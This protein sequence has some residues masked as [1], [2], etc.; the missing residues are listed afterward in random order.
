MDSLVKTL[1]KANLAYHNGQPIM[2][3]DEYDL[4][5]EKLRKLSPNH[6]F[7][8]VIGAPVSKGVLLPYT[9]ASQNKIRANSG[10]LEKWLLRTKNSYIVSDKLD[11]L[12]ALYVN[13]KSL[14]LRGDGVKGVNVSHMIPIIQGL[15]STPCIVRGELVLRK[16]DTVGIGRSI[17]NGWMHRHDDIPKEASK[18]RFVAYQ[19]I[20]PAGM[21]R[22]AQM[23]WLSENGFEIPWWTSISRQCKEAELMKLLLERKSGE[24]PIDGLVVAV[25]SVPLGLSVG[26]VKNPL[27]S[28]A[29]KASLD[30]QKAETTI[31]G[32]VWTTS[33]QNALIPRIQIEP[34]EIGGARIEWLSGHN[35]SYISENRLGTGARIIVRRSGD[36]I[37]CLDSVLEPSLVEFEIPGHDW[38]WDASRVHA[39]VS[40]ASPS[41][42]LL[43]ALQT[44]GVEG[45]GP[46]LVDS[47]VEGGIT[48]M[49]AL[50]KSKAEDLA[51]HI[52]SGRAPVLV[53]SLKKARASASYSTLLVASNRLPRGVG[54]RKMRVLF[55]REPNPRKWTN[56]SAVGWSTESL[57][58]LLKALPFALAW[59]EGSF[60][61]FTAAAAVT[62]VASASA[63]LAKDNKQVVFTGV[64]DK[65]LEL[66]LPSKGYSLQDTVSRSTHILVRDTKESTKTKK[67]AAL[68]ITMMSI[69]EFRNL[70]GLI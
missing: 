7:L 19:L 23:K 64:R 68:G 21:S 62:A 35:A 53:E 27:D 33:R 55:E 46:G 48:T 36:V 29:F 69:S 56:T 51:P 37:P 3:D 49:I 63:P 20:E 70:L 67:A 28:V 58:E 41:K 18:I 45:I 2:S 61:G 24:Y 12:S 54:E 40:V 16:E 59:V 1:Q 13:K 60:P 9:M 42:A 44:L 39:I 26:E 11:G 14:Y 17:V 32:I 38:E 43:H 10:T 57:G 66:L 5:L 34:V 22:S 15:S 30:D 31:V 4:Q 65:E 52:G 50:W 47:L 25:D 8:S 6:P